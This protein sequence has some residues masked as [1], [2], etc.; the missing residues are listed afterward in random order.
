LNAVT[1]RPAPFLVQT[2]EN[3]ADTRT[4]IAVYGTGLRY[5]A[6]VTAQAQDTAGT[7]PLT[8]EY[9]GVAPGFFG[10]DQG[11]LLLPP[12]LDRDDTVSLSLAADGIPANLVPVH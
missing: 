1:Y 11:N 3:G 4:R 9:A 2:P 7:Y 6:K 8:V 12:D 5:A 10:L